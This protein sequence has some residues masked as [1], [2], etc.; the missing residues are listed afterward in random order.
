MS[1]KIRRSWL[2]V[3]MSKPELIAQAAR[4]AADAIVLDL[5]EQ[6]VAA[7]RDA[8]R[9]NVRAALQTVQ[10]GGAEIFAQVDPAAL[11]DDLNA[12]MWPG[13]SGVVVTRAESSAQIAQ[14]AAL[15]SRFENERGLPSGALEIVAALETPLGNHAA[16]EII[17]A[18]PRVSGVTLGRADLIMDLRAEPSHEI[19]LMPYLM[20]RLIIIAGAAGVT[21]I[22]AWWRAPDRGLLA[23]P[24]NT[25]E[26]AHRGRAIGFK[27]AMCLSATQ[28][29]PLN[30]AFAEK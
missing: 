2:L 15:L 21:P 8:A 14:I 5:V 12:C 13:L 27:G 6:V 25:F 11:H 4:S 30:K 9:K 19:H 10:S 3:P 7:D 16:Y 29:E 24:A 23:T 17:S 18:S 28:V 20:Q 26:A 1:K 22:G